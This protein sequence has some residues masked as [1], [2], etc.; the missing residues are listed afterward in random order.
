MTFY[1]PTRSIR[2]L[3]RY[4]I[5]TKVQLLSQEFRERNNVDDMIHMIL[6]W[7]RHCIW[8]LVLCDSRFVAAANMPVKSA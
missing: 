8:K 5:L 1:N 4:S 6:R 2:L 3:I 7:Y